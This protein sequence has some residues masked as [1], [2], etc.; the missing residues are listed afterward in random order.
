MFSQPHPTKTYVVVEFTDRRISFRPL[1]G[2]YYKIQVA[3]GFCWFSVNM[4]DSVRV[5][6]ALKGR[7]F[8][9]VKRVKLIAIYS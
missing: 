8:I 6:E 2:Y 9:L 5:V 3:V 1:D 7:L 4:W